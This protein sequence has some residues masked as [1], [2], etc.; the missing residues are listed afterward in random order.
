LSNVDIVWK[1]LTE[2]WLRLV[3][4]V[5]QNNSTWSIITPFWKCVTGAFKEIG[6]NIIRVKSYKAK[7]NQLWL[8]GIGCIK[9]MISIG[10]VNNEE[11]YFMRN[12]IKAVSNDL[13]SSHH[14]QQYL[15]RRMK[16]GI[17]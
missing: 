17:A 5:K 13:Q 14:Q 1:Y 11:E 12:V 8:Q 9:Q 16:L 3:E 15:H 10:M 6:H 2:K 7:V 4:D